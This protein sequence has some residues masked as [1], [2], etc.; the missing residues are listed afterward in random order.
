[1]NGQTL[2]HPSYLVPQGTADIFF[3]TD[4]QLLQS[5]HQ[6]A[7]QGRGMYSSPVK[8]SKSSLKA[9]CMHVQSVQ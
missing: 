7:N 6:L 5:L 4:F 9:V 1:M 8:P 2:D 3:P